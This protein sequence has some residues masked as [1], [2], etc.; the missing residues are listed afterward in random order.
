ME[1]IIYL[2]DDIAQRVQAQCEDVPRYKP[3]QHLLYVCAEVSRPCRGVRR[4]P[5]SS[6]FNSFRKRQSV[7]WAMIF[8]GVL[9]IIPASWRRR[10]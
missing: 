1:V 2:P 7:P 8:C 10:A 5:F 3:G 6:F 4:Y 9:L